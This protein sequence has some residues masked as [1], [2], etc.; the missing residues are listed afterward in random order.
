M[1]YGDFFWGGRVVGVSYFDFCRHRRRVVALSFVLLSGF[2]FTR[3][4]PSRMR[5]CM[6]YETV[7]RVFQ[8]R[9]V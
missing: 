4:M 2:C 6:S 7:R 9:I 3:D 1:A 5:A 8:V